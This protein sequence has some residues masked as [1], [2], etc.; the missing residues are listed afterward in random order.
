MILAR[1]AQS[2]KNRLF[3]NALLICTTL[4]KQNKIKKNDTTITSMTTTG[5]ISCVKHLYCSESMSRVKLIEFRT[6][7]RLFR[8]TRLKTIDDNHQKDAFCNHVL[9]IIVFR[10]FNIFIYFKISTTHIHHIHPAHERPFFALLF[11]PY[12]S[13][14]PL[15]VH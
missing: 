10:F 1:L 6:Q 5:T 15:H 12:R 9:N 8:L 4:K 3:T 7:L 14:R 11:T 13:I 2:K